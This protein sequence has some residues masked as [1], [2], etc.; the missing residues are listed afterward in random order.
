MKRCSYYYRR[1]EENE[2]KYEVTSQIDI[3]NPNNEHEFLT[4]D[5]TG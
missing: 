4:P 3:T 2:V 1:E 5:V